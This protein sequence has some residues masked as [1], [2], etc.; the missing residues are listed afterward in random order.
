MPQREQE[1]T[2]MIIGKTHWLSGD[3]KSKYLSGVRDGLAAV[4]EI[5][6]SVGLKLAENEKIKSFY[7]WLENE[8]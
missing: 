1:L 2:E 6:D 7:Q 3:Q 4:L 8:R 5:A